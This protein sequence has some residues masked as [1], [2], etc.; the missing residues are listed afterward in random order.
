MLFY[1]LNQYTELLFVSFGIDYNET[2]L[3]NLDCPHGNYLTILQ[4]SYST[5]I[6]IGCV[7]NYD[8]TVYCCKL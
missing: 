2:L 6:D 7:D 4:C 1:F 8:A 5:Y 3:D